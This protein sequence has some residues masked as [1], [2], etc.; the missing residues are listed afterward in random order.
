MTTSNDQ[1]HRLPAEIS[2][3]Q[4]F[5]LTSKF[6]ESTL[7]NTPSVIKDMTVYLSK[8]KGKN[9][10]TRLLIGCAV[11][12]NEKVNKDAVLFASAIEILHL[13]TLV[14]DD[15]MDNAGLR[16]GIPALHT[17]FGNKSAVITGDY[18]LTLAISSLAPLLQKYSR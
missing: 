1:F 3:V 6:I 15:I 4:A 5:D 10:R 9:I 11:K 12:E 17:E 16:R 8:S 2:A 13:A 18:L 14:H 7:Q